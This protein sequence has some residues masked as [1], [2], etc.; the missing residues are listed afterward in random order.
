[1]TDP[2]TFTAD[3]LSDG[4]P[5]RQP[6]QWGVG[7]CHAA[8][9]LR[10]DWQA[11]LTQAHADL[12]FRHVRFH[13]I[14]DDDMGTLIMQSDQ[15][16]YSF[17]NTDR[18][19]DFLLSIGMRPVVELSFMPR[20]LSSGNDIVFHYQGNI[21]PPRDM[22]QWGELVRR[23]A[24]HWVE[25]YG[26][27]E[28]SQWLFECWN[29]PN[30]PAFWTGDQAK[31]FELYR[32][33][34][35]AVKGVDERLQVGGPATA[36]NAWLPEFTAFCAKAGVPY[37]F[38]STHYYPTDP[39]GAIDT[40]TITQLEHSPPGVMRTR[41]LEARQAAGSK[42]LY[43]TE[44]SI[45]SNPRDPFH[46]GSFAAALATR[47]ALD[48]DDVVDGYSYWTFTDIFEE[49]YFPSVPFHG[50]FGMMNLYGI[51]KP[52]YRAFQMLRALGGTR[53][54]VAGA[55]QNVAVWVTG[56]AAPAHEDAGV[57]LINQA[58]PRHAVTDEPVRVRLRHAPGLRAR[59]VTLSR[60][61][62][63]HA[64]PER[65]WR[66]MGAP[67]YLLPAQVDALMAA[68]RTV[69]EAL[70]F[71][72]EEGALGIGLVLAPQSANHIRIEWEPAA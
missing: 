43:Y 46:D 17:F 39:F 11:Q 63:D 32:T 36:G 22:A 42:P 66:E 23:L 70:A 20:T 60:I 44:W 68:S 7:S 64:N 16:L 45:S 71:T 72:Q 37:D 2:T 10:A 53:F 28:V 41:A 12:G 61:D 21:T 31:Y 29:E 27:G 6:W 19:F 59:A 14:L 34:A 65:A 30:L 5:L 69:P 40:D 13:G 18:I 25:R 58:M 24:T 62:A 15:L 38:I 54:A 1:M 67:E 33:T 26:I 48:V 3:L 9:A 56:A 50:G 35:L 55:H 51:P 57:F 52:I 4:M 8:T 47:I 49:N